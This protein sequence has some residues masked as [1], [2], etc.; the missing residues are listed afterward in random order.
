MLNGGS[1]L[2]EAWSAGRALSD[3]GSFELDRKVA[4][5]PIQDSVAICLK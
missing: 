5:K 4:S 1:N 3:K 2:S